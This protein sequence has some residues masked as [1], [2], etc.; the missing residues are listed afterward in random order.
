[1]GCNIFF[2]SFAFNNFF[3]YQHF[4][5]LSW[6]Y[7]MIQEQEDRF[8]ERLKWDQYRFSA[9]PEEAGLREKSEAALVLALKNKGKKRNKLLI[10][11][12]EEV[13]KN[14][15]F[16]FQHDIDRLNGNIK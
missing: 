2:A 15:I 16:D 14:G 8:F 6:G 10:G 7:G 5:I 11:K 12:L 1:M 13:Q 9:N 3:S 4:T